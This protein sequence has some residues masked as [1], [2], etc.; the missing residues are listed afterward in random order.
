LPH[1][2]N[3]KQRQQAIGGSK[4]IRSGVEWIGRQYI[5]GDQAGRM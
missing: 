5:G 1:R 4:A 2:S 3:I